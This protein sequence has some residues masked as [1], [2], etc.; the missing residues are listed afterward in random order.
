MTLPRVFPNSIQDSTFRQWFV[1]QAFGA[2]RML[3]AMVASAVADTSVRRGL[4]GPRVLRRSGQ[5]LALS[6]AVSE[7]FQYKTKAIQ[8][9][10][11]SLAVESEATAISTLYAI[12]CL[13][14]V[15]WVLGEQD[16]IVVHIKGLEKLIAIRGGFHGIPFAIVEN[17]L[18]TLYCSSAMAGS[19]PRASSTP[20]LQTMPLS[21]Q[22]TI[23]SAI[24]PDLREMGF[25]ILDDP[26]VSTLF[27]LRLQQNFS[28]RREALFFRECFHSIRISRSALNPELERYM[29]KRYQLRSEALSAADDD[30]AS[31]VAVSPAE[32]TCHLALLLFWIA[33]YFPSQAIFRRFSRALKTALERS[34]VEHCSFWKPYPKLLMWVLFLGA[35]TS[36]SAC[37][38]AVTGAGAEGDQGGE[39]GEVRRWF[40][41]RLRR[42]A[43]DKLRLRGWEEVRAILKQHFYIDRVY[44]RRFME[45][46]EEITS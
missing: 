29:L 42:V 3:F 12:L 6:P 16:E 41:F 27:S 21:T 35:Y 24:D 7:L 37:S 45:I 38:S 44:R 18:G 46:W 36:L 23:M 9:L 19:L 1:Q 30:I 14:T 4:V 33:N 25:A 32:E 20:T 40:I 22:E 34:D 10:N 13:L 17:M 15:N 2:P 43:K 28:D 26:F 8:L 39:E 5:Q 31:G 11:Q